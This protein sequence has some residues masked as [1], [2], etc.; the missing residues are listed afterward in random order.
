MISV[1]QI[2]VEWLYNLLFRYCRSLAPR[3][4][5]VLLDIDNIVNNQQARLM[6]FTKDGICD[7]RKANG[8]M[9]LLRD[10]PLPGSVDFVRQLSR[11]FQVVW[12]TSRSVKTA[13]VTCYWLR[14]NGFPVYILVCTGKLQRKIS[15]IQIF[16]EDHPIAFVIDDMKEGYESGKPQYVISYREYLESSKIKVYEDLTSAGKKD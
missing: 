1:K 8:F 15:F 9:E 11:R 7:Y 3:K 13:L 6:K 12:L 16:K 5:S 14:R 2:L 4:F 10:E